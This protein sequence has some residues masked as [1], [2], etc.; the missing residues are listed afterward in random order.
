VGVALWRA[1]GSSQH[2]A[3]ILDRAGERGYSVRDDQLVQP[4]GAP[5]GDATE[6]DIYAAAGLPFIPPELRENRGEV[7]A[8][9]AHALP[10]LLRLEDIRGALHCH[11]DYSDG[12]TSITVMAQAAQARGWSYLG[13]SDHSQSAIYAGG[14]DRDAVRKQHEEIDRVNER[15]AGFRVLKGIEADILADGT[16]DYDPDVLARFDYVIASVHSR[17]SMN[18]AQM[19][20][21]ILRAMDNPFVTILGHP[22]GRLLLARESYPVNLDAVIERAAEIGVAIE[23]NCDPH[24]LDLDWRW[25]QVARDR[26]ATIELG[27]DA[28]SPDGLGFIDLG[29]GIA[30]KGWLGANDVLNAG[31]VDAVLRFA[32]ARRETAAGGVNGR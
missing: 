19:T 27:P 11:S 32:R 5:A 20:D 26:G 17:F 1:T 28:H 12:T 18:E 16:V 2:C 25:L 3:V 30:R 23:L 6:A 13:I 29:V 14:L 21:R 22:T 10:V 24:R 8:A 4:D 9:E 31:S 15:L 7:A